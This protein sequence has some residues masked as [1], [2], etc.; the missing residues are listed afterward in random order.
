MAFWISQ[1]FMH[2]TY[3]IHIIVTMMTHNL[4]FATH[5]KAIFASYV[6]EVELLCYAKRHSSVCFAYRTKY[7]KFHQFLSSSPNYLSPTWMFLLISQKIMY[8]WTTCELIRVQTIKPNHIVTFRKSFW[9]LQ[10]ILLSCF[11]LKSLI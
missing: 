9:H 10:N 2:F 4:I 3:G 6:I 5:R 1:V 7:C 11:S 8:I